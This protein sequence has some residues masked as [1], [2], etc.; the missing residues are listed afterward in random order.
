M[1]ETIM[2]T[3]KT[4]LGELIKKHKLDGKKAR[5]S[6]RAHFKAKH[7]KGER[8]EFT[9]AE[10]PKAL[11]VLGVKKAPAKKKKAPTETQ[12]AAAA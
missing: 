10:M 12:P 9:S 2:A 11:E 5:R 4:P 8:W 3:T 1:E 7:T 6:L